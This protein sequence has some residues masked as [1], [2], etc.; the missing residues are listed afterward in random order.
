MCRADGPLDENLTLIVEEG[1]VMDL[2]VTNVNETP[3]LHERNALRTAY[4]LGAIAFVLIIAGQSV[5]VNL[6]VA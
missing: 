5:D 1:V 4:F 6:N 3:T 2:V